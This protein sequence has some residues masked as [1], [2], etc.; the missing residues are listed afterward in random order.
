MNI[1]L[2]HQ[3][4]QDP[5]ASNKQTLHQAL[6]QGGQ[7]GGHWD[8]GTRTLNLKI[9]PALVEDMRKLLTKSPTLSARK[10][11]DRVPGLEN[12]TI[13]TI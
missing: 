5:H 2:S 13:R 10:L 3:A 9:T 8:P 12:I 1:L 11:K 4:V 7:E 6:L